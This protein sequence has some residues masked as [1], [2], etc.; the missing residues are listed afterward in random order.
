ME[1]STVCLLLVTAFSDEQAAALFDLRVGTCDSVR[2]P[3]KRTESLDESMFLSI[4]FSQCFDAI[5]CCF[6][7]IE[8]SCKPTVPE[9]DEGTHFPLFTE[10]MFGLTALAFAISLLDKSSGLLDAESSTP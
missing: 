9:P 4:V 6:S 5:F 7:V 10:G 3:L 8:H 2:E 1:G